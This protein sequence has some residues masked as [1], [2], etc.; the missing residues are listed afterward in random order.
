[1]DSELAIA[2]QE[3][4][5]GLAIATSVKTSAHLSVEIKNRTEC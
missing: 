1:M 4:D 5:I 2:I 3:Q